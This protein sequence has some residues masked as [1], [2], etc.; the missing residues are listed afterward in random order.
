MKMQLDFILSKN[1]RLDLTLKFTWLPLA[2]YKG[3]Q[4]KIEG[5]NIHE[6]KKKKRRL[7]RLFMKPDKMIEVENK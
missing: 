6:K 5:K 7:P 4:Q 1:W 2:K 3:D